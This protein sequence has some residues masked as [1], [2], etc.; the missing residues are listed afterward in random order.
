MKN[1]TTKEYIYD[2][3]D[4]FIK[5][6]QLN[7]TNLSEQAQTRLH[8]WMNYLFSYTAIK[9]HFEELLWCIEDVDDVYLLRE[10]FSKANDNVEEPLL[11]RQKR[12]YGHTRLKNFTVLALHAAFKKIDVGLCDTLYSYLEQVEQNPRMILVVDYVHLFLRLRC[13]LLKEVNERKNYILQQLSLY[14]AG[15]FQ[16]IY[17]QVIRLCNT[18]QNGVVSIEDMSNM[19]KSDTSLYSLFEKYVS[20]DISITDNSNSNFNFVKFVQID[21]KTRLL[22][23]L[24]SK[25]ERYPQINRLSEYISNN[26]AEA[27]TIKVYSKYPQYIIYQD[28][29]LASFEI[30]LF[31]VQKNDPIL[32]DEIINI[33]TNPVH[34]HQSGSSIFT[35]ILSNY[36][37]QVEED[38]NQCL[39]TRNELMKSC[40]M[41]SYWKDL[42]HR[43]YLSNE[44]LLLDVLS[45]LDITTLSSIRGVCKEWFRL[46]V[47]PSGSNHKQMVTRVIFDNEF[48]TYS[49]SNRSVAFKYL[50]LYFGHNLTYLKCD[51]SRI[52]PRDLSFISRCCHKLLYLNLEYAQVTTEVLTQIGNSIPN[53]QYLYLMNPYEVN[54]GAI[55]QN[56]KDLKEIQVTSDNDT[57]ATGGVT[58]NE[59]TMLAENTSGEIIKLNF[60][61]CCKKVSDSVLAKLLRKCPKL[62]SFEFYYA[63]NE[64]AAVIGDSEIVQELCM[65]K[66]L[67]DITIGYIREADQNKLKRRYP[68]TKFK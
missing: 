16:C 35:H 8:A 5:V 57:I 28:G 6:I 27:I 68:Q 40:Q 25:D 48:S 34:I 39:N 13:V 59:L 1:Q 61:M 26:T 55:F 44:Q 3:D 62:R 7:D 41:N 60:G 21:S 14:M 9:L 64:E 63:S 45:F 30:H 24:C 23:I 66:H 58:D 11:K 31:Q 52:H 49:Y 17:E 15:M 47:C 38:C 19:I 33:S 67:E 18:N 43:N 4:S 56:C 65:L 22:K 20:S 51:D 46:I 50:M 32:F 36:F 2:N 54:P 12:I 42:N 29:K 53:L 10:F 37:E